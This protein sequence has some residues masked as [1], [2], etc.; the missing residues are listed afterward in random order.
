[1]IRRDFLKL[2]GCLPII[3]VKGISEQRKVICKK[4]ALKI[5]DEMDH[6]FLNV[7]IKDVSK[8]SGGDEGL[9]FELWLDDIVIA[10]IE[11]PLEQ[12]RAGAKFMVLFHLPDRIKPG[13]KMYMWFRAKSTTLKG[14]I[15]VKSW[16]DDKPIFDK[17]MKKP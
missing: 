3:S 6:G 12:I 15:Q 8:I 13:S 10:G 9:V 16:L 4:K 11:V 17:Q 7:E 2:V 5:S 1:M 14:K